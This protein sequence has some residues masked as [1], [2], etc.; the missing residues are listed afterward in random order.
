MHVHGSL[1]VD[2]YVSVYTCMY[3]VY[4][5]CPLFGI[6]TELSLLKY[7]NPPTNW[8]CT[9]PTRPHTDGH[10]CVPWR[11]AGIAGMCG[12]AA[13]LQVFHFTTFICREYLTQQLIGSDG[14]FKLWR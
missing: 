12:A 2:K 7:M 11:D 5:M 10:C 13:S 6:L 8:Q 14:L 1:H 3:A 9:L 4:C